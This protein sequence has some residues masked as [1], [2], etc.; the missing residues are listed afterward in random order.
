MRTEGQTHRHDESNS[1]FFSQFFERVLN[2]TAIEF[3][4][5][6]PRSMKLVYG[7]NTGNV[8]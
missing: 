1:L 4:Y 2:P 5:Y 7:T 8:R 3:L 6:A